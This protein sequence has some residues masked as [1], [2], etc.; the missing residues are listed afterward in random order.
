VKLLAMDCSPSWT[1]TLK[2]DTF[3]L[4]VETIKQ[5]VSGEWSSMTRAAQ[6]ATLKYMCAHRRLNPLAVARF[7]LVSRRGLEI[8][9]NCYTVSISETG[10]F[11]A[12]SRET[13]VCEQCVFNCC[14]YLA[15]KERLR[16]DVKEVKNLLKLEW[17][18][19]GNNETQSDEENK[20]VYS[21]TP[22]AVTTASAVT[23]NPSNSLHS[24][25]LRAILDSKVVEDSKGKKNTFTK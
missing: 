18:E 24:E 6:N 4:P 16:V 5:V 25:V 22:A 23:A 8:M 12:Y 20:D 1:P 19:E 15:C 14:N 2:E 3:F 7:K 21:Y 9:S 17:R 10:A 13:T 11:P